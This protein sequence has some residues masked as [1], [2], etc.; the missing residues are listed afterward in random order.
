MEP[1]QSSDT[2][3]KTKDFFNDLL[4]EDKLVEESIKTDETTKE[5]D[6][7]ISEFER[8]KRVDCEF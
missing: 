3:Y 7:L 6:D 8:S 2:S 1:P 5:Q 4:E